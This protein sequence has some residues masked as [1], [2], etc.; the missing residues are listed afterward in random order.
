ML[1]PLV[2]TGNMRVEV[3]LFLSWAGAWQAANPDKILDLLVLPEK[4]TPAPVARNR[5]VRKA[6]EHQV[7]LLF[8]LDEDT[9]A[10]P[11]FFE[12]AVEFLK[13]QTD[14]AV[15]GSPYCTAPPEEAVLAF[16]W[17]SAESR[18]QD[19]RWKLERIR[20]EDAAR[21]R[22]IER[23]ANLG[24]GCV[25]LDMRVFDKLDHPYFDYDY[26]DETRTE[27]IET[28]DCYFFRHAAMA[29]VPL[30]IHWDYWSAHFKT[31]MVQR[32]IPVEQKDIDAF[33][34]RQAEANLKTAARSKS[35]P[36]KRSGKPAAR[37]TIPI[38]NAEVNGTI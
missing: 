24:T 26:S 35:K 15:I 32:P 37:Q 27:V 21:R 17:I 6:R 7:D 5:I 1:A 29:G 14:P 11:Q 16:E 33:Y 12:A 31:K 18:T 28:E 38:A 36:A 2:V 34:I 30:F 23:V 8:M 22:G 20:R 4:Y 3:G 10:P 19:V 9:G 25:A 13:Q